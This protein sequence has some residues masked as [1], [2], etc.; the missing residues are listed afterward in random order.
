MTRSR[1]ILR[2]SGTACQPHPG[3]SG[4]LPE[5]PRGPGA[6]G[7]ESNCPVDPR[8]NRPTETIPSWWYSSDVGHYSGFGIGPDSDWLRAS[9]K[10]RSRIGGTTLETLFADGS[11]RGLDYSIT[12]AVFNALVSRAGNEINPQ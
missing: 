10:P 2:R 3:G 1:R 11:V 7:W 4:L 5:H 12:P 6:L 9:L 8:P